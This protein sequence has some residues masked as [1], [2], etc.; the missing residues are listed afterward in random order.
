M[1]GLESDGR[2]G[3]T[4]SAAQ[5]VRRGVTFARGVALVVIALLL[6][7]LAFL[8]LAPGPASVA[9]P[10][11]AHSGDLILNPCSYAT[12]DGSY[13][14]DCGT[15][16]VP[17]N[18][19]VA[20]SRLI[21]LPVT[22]IRARTG[23]PGEPIFRLNGGPGLSNM[24]FPEADRIA[25]SHDVVLVG[26]RGVDGSSDLNCPE[27][28]S[29]L[30]HSA[31]LLGQTSLGAFS[32][33]LSSCARRLQGAGVDLAGY[34]PAAKVDDLEAARK[35]LG[36]DRIDLYSESAGT[37]YAMIYGWRYPASIHRS[38]MVGVNPPGAFL[39]SPQITDELIH[40][41]GELCSKDASCRARTAD[42]TAS[43]RSTAAHLP[44]RFLFL[45]IKKGNV[46]LGSF[47]GLANSMSA[48]A[49]LSAPMTLDSWLSAAQG[50]SS[51]F[52][53]VSL[54]SDFAFPGAFNWG[55]LAA[56]SR[57]DALAA[58]KYFSS[59]GDPGSILGNPGTTFLLGG[60]RLFDA[61]PATA[62]ENEY[63]Q[64]HT[65]QVETLLVG[66]TVDFATPAR[67]ATND[68]LPYLPNG[69]QVVLAE[70]GHTT[71]FW[72]YQPRA[73]VRLLNS[74][75]DTGKIDQSLYTYRT[76][77]FSTQVTQT[78]LGKGFAGTMIG[79]GILA[80]L[81]LLWMAR[82]VNRRGA[83]GRKTSLA[84]RSM[85]PVVLGFGGW[86]LGA[87]VVLTAFPTVPLDDPLLGV[88]AVS[89]PIGLGIYWAWVRRDA[90]AGS[91]FAGFVG[92]IG[93]ALAGGWFGF[94]S[95][96]GL[97][98]LITTIV[99]A[100]A[101]GNLIPIV[102]DIAVARSGLTREARG[103]IASAHARS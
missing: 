74:F 21:G 76:S 101:G 86:F 95:T 85:W 79:V 58:E 67:T 2:V 87:L 48:S 57:A 5:S 41:Y 80:M 31:D 70:L 46:L 69:R 60:G 11:G 13:P 15:L 91:K 10:V 39:W 103:T 96:A 49:P 32:D 36:Y 4:S 56:V 90:S 93:G 7:G 53:F 54:M 89:V 40:H 55:D 52:W 45:P 68:L 29:A 51:G 66:G 6:L 84:L 64:V 88:L 25:A 38:I 73:G 97:L 18:R 63:S 100:A 24:T 1:Q 62:S 72:A 28:V 16:V 82:R 23:T 19:S 47:F 94:T 14:A 12:E 98:A 50:D 65:T 44:D 42:L 59:G 43:M 9:V 17:E 99:G 37:R 30:K 78:A 20:G 34:T 92:A 102:L 81:S 8:R 33:A 26:Y 35:A 83:F 27:V 71:D 3:T 77:D 61:W 22:R 75:F